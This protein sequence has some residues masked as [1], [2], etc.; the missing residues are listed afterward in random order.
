M[1]SIMSRRVPGCWTRATMMRPCF[2][3]SRSR[4]QPGADYIFQW[5]DSST[6]LLTE[7]R[8]FQTLS[9]YIAQLTIANV[10][11]V[12]PPFCDENKTL[13]LLNTLTMWVSSFVDVRKCKL[14]ELYIQI[15]NDLCMSIADINTFRN[16]GHFEW[17]NDS[18]ANK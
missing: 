18:N 10:T 1:F 17:A 5:V 11:I 15:L 2:R 14:D 6:I 4:K 13:S 12:L 9:F 3:I 8:L 7:V 16:N